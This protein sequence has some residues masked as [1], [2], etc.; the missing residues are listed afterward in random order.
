MDSLTFALLRV[1]LA[2][3][4]SDP[5]GEVN[6]IPILQGEAPDLRECDNKEYEEIARLLAGTLKGRD[7]YDL[8]FPALDG[9]EALSEWEQRLY[10]EVYADVHRFRAE[11]EYRFVWAVRLRVEGEEDAPR[12]PA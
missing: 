4:G 11:V 12:V 7:G 8:L 6:I 5:L 9:Y 1:L 3:Y 2:H 10:D